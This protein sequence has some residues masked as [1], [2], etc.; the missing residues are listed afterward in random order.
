[1]VWLHPEGVH[2]PGREGHRLRHA[3]LDLFKSEQFKPEY[4]KINPKASCR[5]SIMTAGLS[6]NPRSSANI[7][8][9][10]P[11]PSLIPA[12]PF[13]RARMRLWTSL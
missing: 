5:R 13:L 6:S 10:L 7:W 12:D 1:M 11:D 3:E 2:H 9:I 4:L 8:T